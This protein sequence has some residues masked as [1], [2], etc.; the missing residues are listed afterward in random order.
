MPDMGN[1]PR[2]ETACRHISPDIEIDGA[3]IK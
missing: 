2:L 1:K 3:S